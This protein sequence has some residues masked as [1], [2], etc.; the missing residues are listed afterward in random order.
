[1]QGLHELPQFPLCLRAVPLPEDA[2]KGGGQGLDRA[3]DSFPACAYASH[4]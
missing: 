3:D 1:M 2:P 4:Y